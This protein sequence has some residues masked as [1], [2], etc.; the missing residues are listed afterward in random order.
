MA[1]AGNYFSSDYIHA[2]ARFRSLA[3]QHNGALYQLPLDVLGPAR[4]ALSI[5]IAWFG[6]PTP[7]SVI[8]HSSG[9]HGVEGFAGSAIQ[10][11]LIQQMPEFPANAALV[12]VHLLNPYG[13][14]WLR[15]TNENNVDLNRNYLAQ[16]SDYQGVPEGYRRLE[17]FINPVSP[18]AMDC[19]YL[20]VTSKIIRYGF[21]TLKQSVAEGQYEFPQ[22]LFYGGNQLE[23]GLVQYQ[24]WLHTYLGSTTNILAI[25]VHTGLGNWGKDSLFIETSNGAM[26]AQLYDKALKDQI[27]LNYKQTVAY[28]I[29]G[30]LDRLIIDA[31][32]Q[33]K[34]DYILQEFGTYSALKV[35]HALREE[36]RQHFYS[37]ANDLA[38]ATKK[39]IFKV[40]NPHLPQWQSAVLQRGQYLVQS[41]TKYLIT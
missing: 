15:R 29:K 8:L 19:F 23:Q 39:N 28:D 17:K 12:L 30:G 18:P 20:N 34:V 10:L 16:Q 3:E 21:Q 22:G 36:N 32:P 37:D 11:Q 9:L 31:C 14:A 41:A 4:Q 2:Q 33:A 1:E 24:S 40:F 38:H 7:K 27:T 6:S 25:D 5:D 35:F 26:Q 13:M